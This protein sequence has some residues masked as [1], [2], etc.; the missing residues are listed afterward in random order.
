MGLV[1]S[2]FGLKGFVKVKSLSGET[3]HFYRLKEVTLRQGKEEKSLEIAEIHSHGDARNASLIIRFTGIGDPNKAKDLTGAEII[4]NREFA[5]PLGE[6][7]YYIEDLK[8]VEV[9]N[10]DCEVL[11]K[12]INVM[13]GGGGQLA[14]IKLLSGAVRLAP[15]RKEFFG[16]IDLKAGKA[17]LLEPWVIE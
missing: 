1:G 3:E 2:P 10:G 9:V 17:M 13:D 15:F 8:D 16:E 7:E 12:I 4:A 6:G 14:E 5:A 11:G